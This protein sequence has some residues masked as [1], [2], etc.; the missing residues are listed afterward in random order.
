MASFTRPSC[1]LSIESL[2]QRRM[3]FRNFE[4]SGEV[5][6]GGI[7]LREIDWPPI[8]GVDKAEIPQLASLIDVGHARRCEFANCLNEAV[9]DPKAGDTPHEGQ[10]IGE[11]RVGPQRFL[12][13]CLRRL[14]IVSVRC[15]PT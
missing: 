12:G 5:R 3:L 14:L 4:S 1:H 15:G 10:E 6:N 7:S 11:E 9:L 13:E 2:E 8:V